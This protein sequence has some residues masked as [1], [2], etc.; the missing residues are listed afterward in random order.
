[1]KTFRSLLLTLAFCIVYCQHVAAQAHISGKVTTLENE[2]IAHAA[3]VLLN[4]E[5]TEWIKGEITNQLGMFE[6]KMVPE[7]QYTIVVSLLG[8]VEY[9]SEQITVAGDD[10]I[11]LGMIV[12]VEKS[13]ALEE[14]NV[15]A[16]KPLIQVMPDRTVFNVANS[17]NSFGT[18]GFEL[19]RRA[20][21]VTIDNAANLVIEGKTGVLVYIDDRPLALRGQD[22]V[23]YLKNLQ[24]RDIEAVE[25]ITQPSSRYDAE[26]N[27]GII[28]IR[29][30]RS[31]S[32]GANGSMASTVTV[33]D[34]AR[35][36]NSANLNY[37]SRKIGAFGNFSNYFGK[38]TG[39]LNLDRTQ[40][41]TNFNARSQSI[42]DSDR[43]NARLA[44][45]YFATAKSTFGMV[46]SG[47]FNQS[48]TQSNSRTPITPHTSDGPT[49]LLIAES[50]AMNKTGNLFANANYRFKDTLGH[51]LSVD[52][53]FGR[54]N[55]DRN[56]LQPNGFFSEDG[57]T[58]IRKNIAFFETPIDIAIF[59]AQADYEQNL[60]KGVLRLGAKYSTV[61][62][63][64][65]FAV[66]D[67]SNGQ[68]IPD[69]TQS[70]T[71]DYNEEITA[72]YF[73]YQKKIKLWELQMGLRM[74]STRS[75]GRLESAEENTNER[76]KRNYS[77]LFPS[78]GI[79]YQL[80]QLNSF[81]LIYSK[82]IQRPNYQSLNP[83]QYRIDEL[84]FRQGNPFLQPQY[85]DNLK[86]SHTF[87]YKLTT[88]LSYSFIADFFAQVTEAR[89]ENENFIMARNV[90]NQRIVNISVSYPAQLADWW[91]MY[92]SLNAFRSIFEATHPD[93]LA[94]AQNTLSIYAQHTFTLSKYF[95]AEVS[96]WY[97][98]PSIWG[99]TYL[100]RSLGALN[101]AVQKRCL[102]EKLS[103]SIGINDLFFTSPWRGS[104]RFGNLYIDG[105]GGSDSRQLHFNIA[106]NFGRNEIKKQ[107][108]RSTGI[109]VEKS[110]LN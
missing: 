83:F 105:S 1:M 87:R 56:D 9:E 58:L 49:Q 55:S 86:L 54:Y 57:S 18:S 52:V 32:F 45:D 90:A 25:I 79:T 63:E 19:L 72:A 17:I 73:N 8:Y 89:G 67:R 14:V 71:F 12:L 5:S 70:N 97:S 11:D 91:S 2:P 99:G 43:N 41:G 80:N 3:V 101:V 77:D 46:L 69:R 60:F 68:N 106:Y 62:T 74:E 95:S 20:P 23:N 47:N 108:Q 33:G 42:Y 21:G 78:G 10:N 26:G 76:V 7:G 109:E 88:S 22:L 48:L 102:N 92:I 64:N 93:F 75:D 28:N 39:F 37:R 104:T 40:N 98:S 36:S 53:D 44:M 35:M 34:F 96:G 4:A 59:S 100:T 29:L 103:I 107:R 50:R 16:E 15:T 66:F 27:A 84:S 13:M 30:K 31:K 85:T 61:R 94:I 110:R 6:F 51:A 65:I 81:A 24:A 82:R 38:S